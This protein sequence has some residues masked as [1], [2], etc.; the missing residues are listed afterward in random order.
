MSGGIGLHPLHVV[1]VGKFAEHVPQLVNRRNQQTI[2][3]L[4]QRLHGILGVWPCGSKLLGPLE[5]FAGRQENVP[6]SAALQRRDI[7]VF[8]LV[9]MNQQF[10]RHF[11]ITRMS[12]RILQRSC[13]SQKLKVVLRALQEKKKKR[14]QCSINQS[15]NQQIDKSMEPIINQSIDRPSDNI[16]IL[17]WWSAR[18]LSASSLPRAPNSF[19]IRGYKISSSATECR[20]TSQVSW[21]NHFIA[22]LGSSRCAWISL[23]NARISLWSSKICSTKSRCG[24][25]VDENR[26]M[27]PESNL[28]DRKVIAECRIT[29]ITTRDGSRQSK[30]CNRMESSAGRKKHA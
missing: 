3:R 20:A 24:V 6:R 15:I 9:H 27:S 21:W 28:I 18:E 17:T 13:I 10:I 2:W 1:V 11:V 25:I 30:K 19:S 26:S 23:Q 7:F 12:R 22:S 14:V 29:C 16:W 4:K 8:L 5:I